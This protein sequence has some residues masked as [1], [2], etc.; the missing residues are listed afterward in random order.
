[1]FNTLHFSYA[2]PFK[3]YTKSF[4]GLLKT[5]EIK[6]I[7]LEQINIWIDPHSLFRNEDNP[8]LYMSLIDLIRNTNFYKIHKDS[9]MTYY[10]IYKWWRIIYW[11]GFLEQ[12]YDNLLKIELTITDANYSLHSN[13]Y[14]FSYTLADKIILESDKIRNNSYL[15]WNHCDMNDPDDVRR[16][17]QEQYKLLY[18]MACSLIKNY[19]FI[20]FTPDFIQEK[21]REL[22]QIGKQEL[23]FTSYNSL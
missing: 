5:V 13:P 23:D 11:W 16:Y 17:K 12:A 15:D 21:F 4:E 14:D 2:S 7:H 20:E 18:D 8:E 10:P 9:Q 1:M 22:I 3:E 6:N 19:S